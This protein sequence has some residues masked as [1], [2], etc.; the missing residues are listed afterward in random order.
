MKELSPTSGGQLLFIVPIV[1]L[2]FHTV[3]LSGLARSVIFLHQFLERPFALDIILPQEQ[4]LHALRHSLTGTQ[5]LHMATVTVIV[6]LYLLKLPSGL[7]DSREILVVELEE[8]LQGG[9]HIKYR[10][11]TH[12]MAQLAVRQ[13]LV[14]HEQVVAEVEEGLAGIALIESGTA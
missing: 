11:H 5:L 3:L 2:R 6:N 13:I 14:E 7:K 9:K 1:V 4:E 8:K 10:S 12:D